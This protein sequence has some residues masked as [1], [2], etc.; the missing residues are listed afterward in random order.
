MVQ[1]RLF[2]LPQWWRSTLT[3]HVPGDLR[4]RAF[5]TVLHFIYG[6][7]SSCFSSMVMS[8]RNLSSM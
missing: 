1:V 7:R 2:L 4:R 6:A 3:Y 5:S 8:N